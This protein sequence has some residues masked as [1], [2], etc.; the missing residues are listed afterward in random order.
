MYVFIQ[1]F[2]KYSLITNS[3]ASAVSGLGNIVIS[4]MREIINE[5]TNK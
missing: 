2:Y 1:L 4:K 5:L 3:I